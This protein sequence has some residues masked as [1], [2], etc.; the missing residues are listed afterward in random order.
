MRSFSRD[1]L[2]VAAGDDLANWAIFEPNEPT[3]PSSADIDEDDADLQAV[4]TDD[5]ITFVD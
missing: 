4:L 1:P 2:C 3:A 5:N